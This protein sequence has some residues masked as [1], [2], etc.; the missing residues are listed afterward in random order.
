MSDNRKIFF[1]T[2]VLFTGLVFLGRLSLLQVF[3]STYRSEAENNII[4][5]NVEFPFRGLIIDREGRMV[6]ENTPSFTL[7]VIPKQVNSKQEAGIM[8]WLSLEKR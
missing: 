8:E 7:Q 4:Q 1:F 6:A 3:D 5:R 2:L